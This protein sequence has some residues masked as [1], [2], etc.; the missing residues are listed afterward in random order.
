MLGNMSYFTIGLLR[1]SSEDCHTKFVYIMLELQYNVVIVLS[2]VASLGWW[3][4]EL[5]WKVLPLPDTSSRAHSW[6]GVQS[7]VYWF[8]W[9]YEGRRWD[10]VS[11][12]LELQGRSLKP[13]WITNIS[14]FCHL[15]PKNKP[16]QS[17]LF[18]LFSCI[19]PLLYS[20]DYF[21]IFITALFYYV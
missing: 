15:V 7:Q 3:L 4:E 19:W 9:G 2:N 18:T 12:T 13:I 17:I 20:I 11:F 14:T 16:A 1:L 8:N 21:M 10:K 6:L 5:I